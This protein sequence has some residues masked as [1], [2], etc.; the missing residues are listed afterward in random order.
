MTHRGI[1]PLTAAGLAALLLAAGCHEGGPAGGSAP[2]TGHAAATGEPP[3]LHAVRAFDLGRLVVDTQGFTLYRFD[4]DTARPPA[5]NCAED[6]AEQWR[7]VPSAGDLR[8]SGF[9]RE[10]VGALRRSDG[11]DQLTLAGWPLYRY[12]KD[13][14]PGETSG[15][16]SGGSWFPVAPDG[17]KVQP[18][19]DAG[20]SGAF[21]L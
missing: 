6:C 5:S 7:P 19:A 14:M 17:K 13:Q 21:G 16:G 11:T 10:L 18:A 12:T 3:A 8:V 15:L 20:T 1:I 4:R 9:D 2:H